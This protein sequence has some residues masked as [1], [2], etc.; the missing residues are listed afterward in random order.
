MNSRLAVTLCAL[1]V[2][3]VVAAGVAGA[4]SQSV[5]VK[6]SPE[7]DAYVPANE[8]TPGT[9]TT[10]TVQLNN[11][12]SVSR[13]LASNR[14]VVTTARN[15]VTTLDDS[16]TMIDV[17]TNEQAI[18]P[19]TESELKDVDFD[20]E[21]PSDVRLGTHRL[22]LTMDY[23]YISK[24]NNLQGQ[25]PTQTTRSESTTET[26]RLQVTK[27]AR[28]SVTEVDDSLR[29]GEEGKITG[30]IENIGRRDATDAGVSFAPNSETVVALENNIAV[31][32]IPAGEST[33]FSIPVEVTS[34]A[35]AVPKR[36]DLPVSFR[37]HNGIRQSDDDPDFLVDVAS[38]RDAFLIEPAD[39]AIE[40][41]ATDTLDIE[42]TNNLDEPVTDIEGKLFADDPLSSEN[43]ETYTETLDPGETATVTVDISAGGDATIKTYP[44]SMDFR[45]TDSNGDSKLSDS[46]RTAI[47][48]TEPTDDGGGLPIGPLLLVLLV[49]AGGGAFLWRRNDGELDDIGGLRDE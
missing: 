46:Y 37:D 24:A 4:Q 1:L 21:V 10:V 28:F 32:D 43:D 12:G 6:G 42:L 34:D 3:S 27:D 44:V 30:T 18:G 22:E 40:A 11:D 5:D 41:G 31:G 23:T 47:S 20:I 48:V 14:E 13:G 45:Y 33:R 39:S 38:Q 35:E 2:V 36:F 7:L 17:T 9:E 25:R 19:V 26:I 16:K 49:V 8:V 15:T 29:V